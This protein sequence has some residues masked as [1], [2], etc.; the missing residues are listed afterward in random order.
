VEYI[1]N[2]FHEDHRNSWL[3]DAFTNYILNLDRRG[4]PNIDNDPEYLIRQM[5]NYFAS[6]YYYSKDASMLMM[7]MSMDYV[8]ENGGSGS[9]IKFAE[10]L[11]QP[12]NDKYVNEYHFMA[13]LMKS[14]KNE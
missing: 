10:Y 11:S 4:G 8:V 14:V 1:R 2:C 5:E 3:T 13:E 6:N 7:Y 12:V 9:L